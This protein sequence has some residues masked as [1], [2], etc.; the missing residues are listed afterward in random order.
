MIVSIE[1][2]PQLEHPDTWISYFPTAFLSTTSL[3]NFLPPLFS[4]S[5]KAGI[6]KLLTQ[7]WPSSASVKC[8]SLLIKALALLFSWCVAG[9][10]WEHHSDDLKHGLHHKG[11]GCFSPVSHSSQVTLL[12]SICWFRDVLS[13]LATN[14]QVSSQKSQH[15][16][17]FYQDPAA[18]CC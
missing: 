7:S 3:Q 18:N 13:H 9:G 16:E 6:K 14:W 5:F 11:L 17:C 10:T 1:E 4:P 15:K 2:N 8:Q 12:E